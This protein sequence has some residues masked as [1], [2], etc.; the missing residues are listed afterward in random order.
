MHSSLEI[1]AVWTNLGW[2]AYNN[3]AL[4]REIVIFLTCNIE[5]GH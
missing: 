4:D 2:E 1:I 3:A 5:Q